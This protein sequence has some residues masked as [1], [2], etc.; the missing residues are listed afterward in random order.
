MPR[1]R[2]K[3]P[4]LPTLPTLSTRAE[5]VRVGMDLIGAQGFHHTGL[6]QILK[7][8]QVPKGSFYHYFASKEDFGLAV[9]EAFATAYDA[10]LERFLGDQTARPLARLRAYLEA[11]RHL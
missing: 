11:G 4:P 7:S 1:A 5:I 10:K 2:P 9:I 3:T 8:A 6:D